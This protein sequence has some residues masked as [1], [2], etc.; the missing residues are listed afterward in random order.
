MHTPIGNEARRVIRPIGAT[1]SIAVAILLAACTPAPAVPT[2]TPSP[3]VT[4]T[5][6][7]E[8]TAAPATAIAPAQLFDG[9]CDSVVDL[10]ALESITGQTLSPRSYDAEVTPEYAAVDVVGGLRCFWMTPAT[11]DD[12]GG[13]I[14]DDGTTPLWNIVAL[15]IRGTTPEIYPTECTEGWGCNFSAVY[16]SVEVYGVLFDRTRTAA[17]MTDNVS[18]MLAL[19]EPTV[20]AAAMPEVWSPAGAWTYPIDCATLA[21]GTSV[22]AELGNASAIG[23]STGGDSEPNTGVYV[24]GRATGLVRCYWYNDTASVFV[25]FLPAGGWAADAVAARSTSAPAGVDGADESY[26]DREVLHVFDDGNWLTFSGSEGEG[27]PLAMAGYVDAAAD[28][29]AEMSVPSP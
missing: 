28:M 5:P 15:P 14:A 2:A 21:S 6:T 17:A 24:A 12:E 10:A 26:F 19:L 8:P 4:A 3:A 1:V 20:T 11:A 22:A 9:D 13:Y 7:S 29:I 25:E 16:G 27:V 18:S 23:F